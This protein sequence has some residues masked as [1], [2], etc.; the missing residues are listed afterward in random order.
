MSRVIDYGKLR[1]SY[2]TTGNDQIGDYV[3]LSLYSYNTPPV[4]YLGAP[5]LVQNKLTNP[6]IQW[7]ETKKLSFGL[8]LGLFSDRI[9]VNCNYFIN[10]SSNLI[11]FGELPSTAGPRYLD[12]NLPAVVRNSGL[13]V[14]L[15]TVNITKR[16]F[17]WSSSFNLTVSRNSLRRFDNLSS[18]IYANDFIIGQS[19]NIIKAYPFK[20]VDS[21]EGRYL[22]TDTDGN[23]TDNPN[24]DPAN[25]TVVINKDPKFFGGL[26][27]T[28]SYKGIQLDFLL[29]VVK[30]LAPK[31]WPAP[32]GSNKTNQ[33]VWVLD[34]W[35]KTG[36]QKPVQKYTATDF[37]AYSAYYN[38]PFSD[39]FYVDA[40]YIRL[41]NAS[42]S[43]ILPQMIRKKLSL[44]NGRVFI[45]C[46][47]LFTITSFKGLDP[48][49]QS[50]ISLPPLRVFT[51]GFQLTF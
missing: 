23:L 27:N 7:E 51:A 32:P 43:Y 10:R 26:G 1:V 11:N 46:Q 18:S 33:P 40:S 4:P 28:I 34:R 36:D 44:E 19:I 22:F 47:N 25:R 21:K 45:N 17:K 20:G 31:Y 12:I 37:K 3:Y 15:N 48:E 30:Q 9:L 5:S 42:L 38:V 35:Q 6:Y 39:D 8:D 49:T 2:G 14:L 16:N 29:Q 13:E 41:K 50:S 24:S